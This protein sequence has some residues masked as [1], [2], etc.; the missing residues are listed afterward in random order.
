MIFGPKLYT[1]HIDPE[2][3]PPHGDA[4]FVREGFNIFA[5][6]FVVFWALYHRLWLVAVVLIGLQ[7]LFIGLAEQHVLS[8]ISANI[9][10]MAVQVLFGFHANDL[11][12]DKLK[13]RGYI[14]A[15][16]TTGESQL[17][18]EQRF[19]ERFLSRA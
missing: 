13:K 16:V 8:M 5:F 14:L 1:V 18:A 7:A 2:N 17:R 12:C 9:F 6:L 19:F 15:D 3:P 4:V 10:Y 11:R